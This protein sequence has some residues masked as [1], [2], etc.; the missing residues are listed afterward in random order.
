MVSHLLFARPDFKCFLRH[1][2]ETLIWQELLAEQ[3]LNFWYE[4]LETKKSGHDQ[5]NVAKY[6]TKDVS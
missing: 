1:C 2:L 6:I 5:T 4:N 3:A